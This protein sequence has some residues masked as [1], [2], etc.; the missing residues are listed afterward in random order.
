MLFCK[1]RKKNSILNGINELDELNGYTLWN[2][3][4][5]Y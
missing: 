5:I 4:T 2:L 1:A 3:I